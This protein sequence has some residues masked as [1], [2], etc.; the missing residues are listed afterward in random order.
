MVGTMLAPF[1]PDSSARILGNLGFDEPM[2]EGVK[3]SRKQIKLTAKPEIP[4]RRLEDV[5][6]ER[7]KNLATKSRPVR[8]YFAS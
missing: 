3:G 6:I 7:A 2:L 5:Q 4:F 1:L 8:D